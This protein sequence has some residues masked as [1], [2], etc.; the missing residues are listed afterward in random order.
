MAGHPGFDAR[1]GAVSGAPQIRPAG[2]RFGDID[3][4]R[5]LTVPIAFAV[6][7]ALGSLS[8]E[9]AGRAYGMAPLWLANVVIV[10]PL[11]RFPGIKRLE[12]LAGAFAG[13]TLASIANGI[14]PMLALVLAGINLLEIAVALA[15]VARYRSRSVPIFAPCNLAVFFVG[16]GIIAPLVAGMSGAALLTVVE[17]QTFLPVALHWFAAD[18]LGM[19]VVGPLI[20]AAGCSDC[21][22][23]VRSPRRREVAAALLGIGLTTFGVFTQERYPALFLILPVIMLAIFR[24]RFIGAAIGVVTVASVASSLTLNGQGPIAHALADMDERLLFL[25]LFL[26]VVVVAKFP[27]AAVLVEREGMMAEARD[28]ERRFRRLA[29]TSPL[30]L[31]RTDEDGV[32]TYGNAKWCEL[33]GATAGA[34]WLSLVSP[35][36]QR[37]A[38]E[39]WRQARAARHSFV[40]DYELTRADGGANWVGLALNPEIDHGGRII[41]WTGA[42]TDID[43]RRRAE[44]AM[45]ESE[46]Q[47]RLLA[48]HSNDMIVRIGLDGIRRFVSP[49]CRSILGFEPEELV[50]E[51]PIAAIHPEDRAR[52]EQ[53][54]RS[55]LDSAIEPMCSYRQRRRD[56]SY[57]WLEATYRLVTDDSG[58]P[59][60]FVASVRDIGR[61]LEVE[62]EKAAV[63]ARLQESNRLLSMAEGMAGVGHWRLDAMTGDLFWSDEVFHIHGRT[64]GD[65]P[66]LAEAIGAYH[67]DDRPVVQRCVSKALTDGEPWTFRARIICPDGA[68]RHVQSSGQVE[69]A[70]DGTIVGVVGVFRDITDEVEAAAA[71]LSAR[72]EARASAE[73]KSAFLATMS[74][75]IRTPMTGVL[76][77]IELLRG[78]VSNEDK[79]RFFDHLERS[80]NLLMTVLDDVLDFSKIE[81]DHLVLEAVDFDLGGLARATIDLFYHAASAKGLT[82]SLIAPVGHDLAVRGDPVRL[83]QVMANLISNAIKFTEA[84]SVELRIDARPSGRKC[85]VRIEVADT[86]IGIPRGAIGT[87][88]DPFVQADASTT[89]R[90]GGSGL[91][92]AICKRLLNAMDGEIAVESIEGEGARFV[93]ELALEYGHA[94]IVKPERLCAGV[95]REL[96]ILLA[97]DNEITRTLVE[98]LV[99]KDGHRIVSVENGRVAHEVASQQFFDVILMDMQMPEMDGVAASR[100]IRE[101]G[102]PSASA[103]I[104]AL[105]ADALPERRPFYD[106]AGL[107]GFLTKPIDPALLSGCLQAIAETPPIAAPLLDEGKLTSLDH[108][109]GQA[110]TRK[111]LDLLRVELDERPQLIVGMIERGSRSAVMAEAHALKGATFNVGA[112]RVGA[113]ARRIELAC[114][115]DVPLAPLG[116][117]LLTAAL[118]TRQAIAMR[119]E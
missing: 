103:P 83:Q 63:S 106:E 24:L 14:G 70:P 98:A 25:Q 118:A 2:P 96:S 59:I 102:G 6:T 26:A 22:S 13:L 51:T 111:L 1:R 8:L 57:V 64:I 88:F 46:R 94:G 31:F 4:R 37:S 48:D 38:A 58:A 90:F 114:D 23:L 5:I 19:F 109:V 33:F 93:C 15:I 32:V 56:G 82:L 81:S 107:T 41:A 34:G 16:A 7:L 89:R 75:E 85:L 84:G 69:R 101:S 45:A 100:A 66:S 112:T 92:L 12:A 53:V 80:A 11:I 95:T 68:C 27:V 20:L 61:R 49:A 110:G 108:V 99:R 3:V 91:G 54:C 104:I 74:H 113:I 77:M 52:V 9:L 115:D 35:Q 17:R 71:L 60:E 76:G 79:A 72:D 119:L 65:L 39:A 18:A 116:R 10:A 42:A 62:L 29:E 97:E 86:G 67:E 73:A 105:T 55:L 87:L 36:Q 30:A 50:G 44:L 43:E 21:L 40:G 78:D 117:E 47:Y 28:A